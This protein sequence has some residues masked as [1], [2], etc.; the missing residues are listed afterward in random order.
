[1]DILN[2]FFDRAVVSV[3]YSAADRLSQHITGPRQQQLDP[4]F[5]ILTL[6]LAAVCF[7]GLPRSKHNDCDHHPGNAS[8]QA[9]HIRHDFHG[10]AQQHL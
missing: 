2:S 10:I 6:S 7:L 5:V 3:S 1:M 8:V 9:V 4:T